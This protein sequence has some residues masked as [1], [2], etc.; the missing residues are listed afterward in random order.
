MSKRPRDT[1]RSK[2]YAAERTIEDWDTEKM[3]I[4]EIEEW[5]GKITR[6]K[7]WKNHP[8]GGSYKIEVR[9]GRGR[10]NAGGRRWVGKVVI[11][12]PRWS[13][14]KIVTL[15]EIAHG[16]QPHLTAWHGREFCR[17][18][19]DLVVRWM[20]KDVARELR[21]SFVKHRVKHRGSSNGRAK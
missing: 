7:W 6:S 20:G 5:V 18:F 8:R 17:T 4:P 2:V 3:S 16:M 10:R 19:L 21:Q 13:R 9:D 12:M 11:K 14:T 1:Q 15:H